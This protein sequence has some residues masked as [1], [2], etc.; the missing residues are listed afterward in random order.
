MLVPPDPIEQFNSLLQ[1]Y[2]VSVNMKWEQAVKVMSGDPRW[3]IIGQIKE[4]KRLFND[5]MGELKRMEKDEMRVRLNQAKEDFFKMLE[6]YK[7]NNS[8]IKFWKV[9]NALLNDQRWKVRQCGCD[10]LLGDPGG[11]GPRVAVPGSPGQAV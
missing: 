9:Q 11:E 10:F 1:D 6:E 7:I 4:K 2:H 5:Y 3:K 8:D